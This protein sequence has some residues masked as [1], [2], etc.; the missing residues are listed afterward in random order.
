MRC[1]VRHEVARTV[2]ASRNRAFDAFAGLVPHEQCA[3]QAQG[4]QIPEFL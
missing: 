1:S 3:G 4:G 2:F